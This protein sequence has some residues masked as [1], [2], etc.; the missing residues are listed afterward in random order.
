MRQLDTFLYSAS[1]IVPLLLRGK[2][3]TCGIF[4]GILVILAAA[5]GL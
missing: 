1:D 3:V 2:E 4:P 5:E